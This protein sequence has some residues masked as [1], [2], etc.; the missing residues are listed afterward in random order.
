MHYVRWIVFLVYLII[1]L[2]A[3]VRLL[4]DNRQPVKTMAWLLVLL[5]LP[6]LGLLLYAFFGQNARKERLISKRSLDQLSRRAM[7]EYVEQRNLNIPEQYKSIIKLF[8][9]QSLSLPFKDNEVKIYTNGADFFLQL[10]QAIGAAKHHIHLETYIFEDDA[11]GNLIA[12]MLID[13][14]QEGVEVR[15][16]YDDVGCWTVDNSFFKRMEEGGVMVHG[17]M[18]VH[19]P[20]LTGKVNYRNHRKLCVID[21]K[22][23]FIGGMNIALRYIKG[24]KTQAWR[25]THLKIVGGGVYAIQGVF[26]LSWYFVSR[27]LI[28]HHLY[29]PS[30]PQDLSNDCLIQVVSGSPIAPWPAIMQGFVRSIIEAKEYVYI[31]TPYFLPTE[32]ILFALRTASLSGVDVRVML[33]AK[34]DSRLAEWAANSYIYKLLEA[35]ITV[36]YYNVGFNHSKFMVVDD[37]LA[38]CGS[39]NVDFRSFENNFEANVFL[40][41]S[42]LAKEFKAI[43]L[44][45]LRHCTVIDDV[46]R[47]PR[48][49]FLR[50]LWESLVRLLAPLL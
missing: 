34:G 41:D 40:Y 18:P 38:S 42:A 31:E 16:I 14:A 9:Q 20:M 3:T 19:F 12:D 46:S 33:P 21:G 11:L 15:V 7:L 45:D 17:F 43:F 35:G 44:D 28:S 47:L 48:Q 23:G 13:K 37:R 29:Y 10:M 8:T 6:G 49:H 2:V 22:V 1:I 26:L 25:D 30:L 24:T 27:T 32:P 36:C 50:R 39:T 5:F 4:L